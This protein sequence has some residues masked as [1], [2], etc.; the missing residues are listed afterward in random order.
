MEGTNETVKEKKKLHKFKERQRFELWNLMSCHREH[1]EM[2][3]IDAAIE[4]INNSTNPK[5]TFL[6]LPEYIT[7]LR[8]VGLQMTPPLHFKPRKPSGENQYT[9]TRREIIARITEL[10]RKVSEPLTG[11]VELPEPIKK[12]IDAMGRDIITL[13]RDVNTILAALNSLAKID[14]RINRAVKDAGCPVGYSQPAIAALP[15]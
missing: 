3:D 14:S 4:W 6:V 12:N 5:L 15:G 7:A 9:Q 11:Y 1:L 2:L 13:R 10:E 8:S